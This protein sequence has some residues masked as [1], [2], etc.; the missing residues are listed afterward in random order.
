MRDETWMSGLIDSQLT[1]ITFQPLDHLVTLP[2]VNI[3]VCHFHPKIKF[4]YC[5]FELS[6]QTGRI[7]LSDAYERAQSLVGWLADDY[8]EISRWLMT[9]LHWNCLLI[10]DIYTLRVEANLWRWWIR[11]SSEGSKDA[12]RWQQQK[13]EQF[14]ISHVNFYWCFRFDG[15][16]MM[17]C[18]KKEWW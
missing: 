18:N 11:S 7:E 13:L 1:P 5:T 6:H 17:L 15:L 2:V 16:Y 14:F 9:S 4:S 3:Y 8:N 10:I 12:P